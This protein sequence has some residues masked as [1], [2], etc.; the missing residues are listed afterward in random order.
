MLGPA[1]FPYPGHK[2]QN[3]YSRYL[4]SF[5]AATGNTHPCESNNFKVSERSPADLPT[6]CTLAGASAM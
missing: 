1:Q 5:Q 4:L 6:H 3:D 2:L